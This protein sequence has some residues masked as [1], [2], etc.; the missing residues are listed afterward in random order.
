MKA[1]REVLV[2]VASGG[3]LQLGGAAVA[4]E[5]AGHDIVCAQLAQLGHVVLHARVEGD[6]LAELR[7]EVVADA[8]VLAN[9]LCTTFAFST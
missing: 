6:A 7:D 5:V 1:P 2:A 4:V 9:R 8:Y 3:A